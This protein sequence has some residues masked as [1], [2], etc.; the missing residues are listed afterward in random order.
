MI[1]QVDELDQAHASAR[2]ELHEQIDVGRGGRT[3]VGNGSEQCDPS[4]ACFSQLGA[5][6][7]Q[8]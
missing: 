4:D 8:E 2:I 1:A 7:A 5:P 6:F 3:I